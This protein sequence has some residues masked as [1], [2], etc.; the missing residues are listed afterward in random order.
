MPI[1]VAGAHVGSISVEA[2]KAIRRVR[3]NVVDL[4]N[5]AVKP[6]LEVVCSVH[7]VQ[8]GCKLSCVLAQSVVTIRVSADVRITGARLLIDK[9]RRHARESVAV[10]I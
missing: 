6:K 8:R 4:V 3:L 9:D 2:K 5:A 1:P 10:Q 7:L